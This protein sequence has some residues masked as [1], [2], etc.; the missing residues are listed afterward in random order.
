LSGPP[1]TW[2][3][4]AYKVPRQPSANRVFVWRKLKKL[5]AVALQ[6][7]VWV[8]PSSTQT[9]EHFRWLASEIDEIGGE[10]TLWEATL[11]SDQNDARLLKQFSAPVEAE[12][13]SIMSALKKK[14]PDLATLGRRYQLIQAQDYFR[15]E[16]GPKVRAA[17]LAAK[18]G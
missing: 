12:Y 5:G 16:L 8:L 4:L 6:D 2:L 14:A 1:S 3:L 7:A 9:R 18:G 17:L 15:S 11:M 10:T 13:R